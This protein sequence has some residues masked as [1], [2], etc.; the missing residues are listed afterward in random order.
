MKETLAN[1][2]A[3]EFLHDPERTI[4]ADEALISSGLVDSFNLV[5]LALFIEGEYGV[6]LDDSELTASVFDTLDELADL[7]TARQ[8]A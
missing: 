6:R 1:Y 3:K 2:I 5:D 4:A 7:I 8:T